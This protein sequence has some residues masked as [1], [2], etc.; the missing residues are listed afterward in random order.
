MLLEY[1]GQYIKIT[2]N[3]SDSTVKHY[4]TALN[5]INSLLIKYKFPISSVF[6]VFDIESLNA[7]QEFLKINQEFLTKDEVGN[8]MYSVAFNHF[9]RFCCEDASFFDKDIARMDVVVK[10][11]QKQSHS[12]SAYTRNKIIISQALDGAHHKCEHN[13]AHETF[14]RA[15]T[16]KPYMEGHHLIPMKFQDRFDCSIDVYANVVCLC[17]ICHRLLHYGRKKDKEYL[18]EE[19]F[20]Q[21]MDRLVVS[22]IDISKKEFLNL[23]I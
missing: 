1:F 10:K 6:E 11:P 2:R 8:R 20:E 7:I 9:Y 3:V 14:I 16:D 5:T 19:L 21:R 22:G 12:L 17:P 15:A 4:V 18:S 13:S 23:V